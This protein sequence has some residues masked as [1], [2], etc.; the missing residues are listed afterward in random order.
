MW[1][2]IEC[3]LVLK[4][5]SSFLLLSEYYIIVEITLTFWGT[6]FKITKKLCLLIVTALSTAGLR[7]GDRVVGSIL[8]CFVVEDD[9]MLT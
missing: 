8:H 1:L 4:L 6:V 3:N 5:K 9:N 7:T 2:D